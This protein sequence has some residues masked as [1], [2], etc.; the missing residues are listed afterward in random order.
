MVEE[1]PSIALNALKERLLND[2]EVRVSVSSIHNYLEGRLFTVKKV[3]YQ[4]VEA[5]N[6]RNKALRLEYFQQ[7]STH[8]LQNKTIVWI[9]EPNFNL[10]CRRTRGRAPAGQQ[11]VVALPGSKAPNVYVIGAIT[12]WNCFFI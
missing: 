1:N 12:H 7:I 5:N 10:Y 4:T 3:H 8:M 2:F 6:P 11:A 9:D